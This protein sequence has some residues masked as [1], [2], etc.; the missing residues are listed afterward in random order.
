M[1]QTQ[2]P[3]QQEQ[4]KQYDRYKVRITYTDEQTGEKRQIVFMNF[5]RG[6]DNKYHL[7]EKALVSKEQG[8]NHYAPNEAIWVMDQLDHKRDLGLPESNDSHFVDPY[9][10]D[11]PCGDDSSIA[12]VAEE[13]GSKKEPGSYYTWDWG[14]INKETLLKK[15]NAS[16][17][18][19]DNSSIDAKPEVFVDEALEGAHQNNNKSLRPPQFYPS[20]QLKKQLPNK[21][22]KNLD[23]ELR[24]LYE[25]TKQD[26]VFQAIND[27][28]KT[29]ADY[30]PN[31][32]DPQ[33]IP[34]KKSIQYDQNNQ[35]QINAQ[36]GE[37]D[38]HNKQ[39]ILSQMVDKQKQA[40]EDFDQKF[41]LNP[42]NA[43]AQKYSK[44]K[45]KSRKE[46]LAGS[47][48]AGR[49]DVDL[50]SKGPR[51]AKNPGGQGE[52]EKFKEHAQQQYESN[53][54][55]SHEA[56]TQLE[57][58]LRIND[59]KQSKYDDRQGQL[60]TATSLDKRVD[61]T[62]FGNR[63]R[64]PKMSDRLYDVG[65]TI[66]VAAHIGGVVA[67][68]G[69][70]L[71]WYALNFASAG[72][73]W[74]LKK[75]VQKG[76]QKAGLNKPCAKVWNGI[77][78]AFKRP[79][80]YMKDPGAERDE[81]NFGHGMWGQELDTHKQSI[82]ELKQASQMWR[83]N[84]LQSIA[85]GQIWNK[86]KPWYKQ[87]HKPQLKKALPFE[88]ETDP[89]KIIN[90]YKDE[91]YDKENDPKGD[92]RQKRNLLLADYI[93]EQYNYPPTTT[94]SEQVS[95]PDHIDKQFENEADNLRQELKNIVEEEGSNDPETL[96][97]RYLVAGMGKDEDGKAV[98]TFDID[99]VEGGE[100]TS[101]S[102]LHVRVQDLKELLNSGRCNSIDEALRYEWQTQYRH[103]VVES[104]AYN[105]QYKREWINRAKRLLEDAANKG[106]DTINMDYHAL[107]G[108]G[109]L[110]EKQKQLNVIDFA[111]SKGQKIDE[112]EITKYYDRNIQND[113]DRASK[114]LAQLRN[115]RA[116]Q[117][118]G[119]NPDE[120]VVESY[121]SSS[122]Q[123]LKDRLGVADEDFT[124]R[125]ALQKG[126]EDKKQ[127]LQLA[128][129][130]GER[131]EFGGKLNKDL[132]TL[133]EEDAQ[134]LIK[135]LKK[136]V[137]ENPKGNE[138]RNQA[139]L[140]LDS[141]NERP[142][143]KRQFARAQLNAIQ[144]EEY[145]QYLV[146]KWLMGVK[147]RAECHQEGLRKG[148]E[149]ELFSDNNSWMAMFERN[150]HLSDEHMQQPAGTGLGS[151]LKLLTLIVHALSTQ[152]SHVERANTNIS[153]YN[154]ALRCMYTHTHDWYNGL[155]A[156]LVNLGLTEDENGF[157]YID[158]ELIEKDAEAGEAYEMANKD[159]INKSNTVRVN[160]VY[161]SIA[162]WAK[163]NNLKVVHSPSVGKDLK[164]DTEK[165]VKFMDK[166][167]YAHWQKANKGETHEASNQPLSNPNASNEA[168]VETS[169]EDDS[170]KQ[171]NIP[172]I[173]S[174][175][176]LFNNSPEPENNNN[177]IKLGKGIGK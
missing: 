114:Q 127:E 102:Q 53:I 34:Q 84:I 69:K 134:E 94:P 144:N 140:I 38:I 15:L 166:N 152:S 99:D 124:F 66:G 175:S 133:S 116:Q 104:E 164:N 17:G 161:I 51:A 46:K 118:F 49:E 153:A 150:L 50:S 36:A 35:P 55:S 76:A 86:Q 139:E 14:T 8:T 138:D 91:L 151:F 58:N 70:N 42:F 149:F 137:S 119:D 59:T 48:Q 169:P 25:K 43:L 132:K 81:K 68:V 117:N 115:A 163:C 125:Q 112:Q 79:P 3:N 21:S 6:G 18:Q 65:P 170:R 106:E 155:K 89:Q 130:V 82:D 136:I 56:L 64:P 22:Q 62:Q 148:I 171:R 172:R 74:L 4:P 40:M 19:T 123:E 157:P 168:D 128:Y 27:T 176:G 159:Q 142:E 12:K 143:I 167:K 39:K 87:S 174:E 71:G 20:E 52:H 97:D 100:G 103:R 135:E 37:V 126:V 145:Q 154:E 109:K 88:G 33:N 28:N 7:S 10:S 80:S 121:V 75:G 177:V 131:L 160:A 67:N 156:D 45:S 9:Q 158:M 72:V 57:N 93:L 26:Q 47:L 13:S 141:L 113:A 61:L 23:E 54:I 29:Y 31:S 41:I 95:V 60:K 83:Q 122:Y 16:L 90:R 111:D 30:D 77:K 107:D 165:L 147:R 92:V 110:I 24:N 2:N 44:L 85:E 63:P 108:E 98:R 78:S 120:D 105:R 146:G 32:K 173:E 5:D 1:A 96:S 11:S 129:Q 101:S 162:A 73:P